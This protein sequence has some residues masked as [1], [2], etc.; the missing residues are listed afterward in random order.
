MQRDMRN[1]KVPFLTM[2]GDEDKICLPSG[3]YQLYNCNSNSR[4]K[5]LVNVP[6][7]KH[8]LILEPQEIRNEVFK[9]AFKWLTTRLN[10]IEIQMAALNLLDEEYQSARVRRALAREVQVNSWKVKT[11]AMSSKDWR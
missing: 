11:P 7:A 9:Q 3:S 5:M 1:V 10:T 6:G 8:H 4:D 2:H